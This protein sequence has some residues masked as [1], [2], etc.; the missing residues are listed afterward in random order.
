M[1]SWLKDSQV[2]RVLVVMV[3]VSPRSGS[4]NVEASKA[5]LNAFPVSPVSPVS[6]GGAAARGPH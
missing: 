2:G 5:N 6:G 4:A 3:T 1:V